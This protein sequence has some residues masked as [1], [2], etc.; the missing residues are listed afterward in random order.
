VLLVVILGTGCR[1]VSSGRKTAGVPE[2]SSLSSPE[3]LYSRAET[4]LQEGR[5][6]EAQ[7]ILSAASRE[8]SS[9]PPPKYYLLQG[10]LAS[11]Q[12]R[13]DRARYYLRKL[14]GQTSTSPAVAE[15]LLL[16]ADLCYSDRLVA[17]AFDDYLETVNRF[18]PLL[19]ETE[20]AR[21]YTRLAVI[22]FYER[23]DRVSAA[24][25]LSVA[26]PERL[27]AGDRQD[28][29]RILKQLTW[30]I[31]D[32]DSLGVQDGNIS[33]LAI[34]GDDLWI[35]TWNGGV[36]RYALSAD[37]ME[38]FRRGEVSLDANTVRTIKA[39][40]GRIWVGSYK[41]LY[42]FS[43]ATSLW[44]GEKLFNGPEP[45]Q[46]EVLEE[47]AGRLYA[48]TLG[49]GLYC[50]KDRRWEQVP[51]LSDG[52]VNALCF[53][54]GKLA[55]GTMKRGLLLFD[56]ESG[57]IESFAPLAPGLEAGNIT[58]LLVDPADNLWI[59]TYG[60]GLYVWQA[61]EGTLRHFSRSR[62]EIPDD[63]ILAGAH[64]EGG[65]GYF[66]TFGGGV[67]HFAS[68][69]ARPHIIGL[70]DGLPSLDI[71]AVCS[72]PPFIYFGTLGA[73]VAIHYVHDVQP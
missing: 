22:A 43:R 19:T 63:W 61:A 69:S 16:L 34:D 8:S 21:L 3:T 64:F 27:S 70:R 7:E 55:V 9:P 26:A 49:K 39:W 44:S 13:P 52:Y 2:S 10:R 30:R 25:F 68:P 57:G 46:V 62:G 23:R 65:G 45:I 51:A 32:S 36:V 60:R 42:S 17:S 47:A 54:Q 6:A 59:G 73:G 71:S 5:Y 53:Y 38:T 35:G 14:S 12:D 11:A 58:L 28:Y 50:L 41:G 33:A 72:S 56:P 40:K 48:G 37:R 20:S 31:L 15:G 66:G 67:V 29:Q 18:S 24:E 1:L 4:L